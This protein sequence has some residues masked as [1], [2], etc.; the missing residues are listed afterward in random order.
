M[1]NPLYNYAV[2]LCTGLHQITEYM[3]F[4][5]GILWSQSSIIKATPTTCIAGPKVQLISTPL[6]V[7]SQYAQY[8]CACNK[9]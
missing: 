3:T 1:Y 2:F 4:I 5:K 6:D 7:V 9:K 8:E